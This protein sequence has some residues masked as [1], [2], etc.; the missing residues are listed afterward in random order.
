MWINPTS[1]SSAELF[2]HRIEAHWHELGHKQVSARAVPKQ[3]LGFGE[4]WGV[5]S[6]LI[7]GLPPP[8]TNSVTN[9]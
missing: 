6:N 9:A 1:Q 4:V 5:R 8:T 7:R 3:V 2:A